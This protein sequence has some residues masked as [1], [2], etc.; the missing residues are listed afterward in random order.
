MQDLSDSIPDLVTDS[1][2]DDDDSAP[3]TDDDVDA[4]NDYWPSQPTA[5]R[6]TDN[7]SLQFLVT[8]VPP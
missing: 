1:D 5:V 3:D 2:Y 7:V 6:T 8:I 4:D